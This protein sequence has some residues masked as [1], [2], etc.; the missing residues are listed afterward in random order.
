MGATWRQW[1]LCL[2][3]VAVVIGVGIQDPVFGIGLLAL[4]CLG[5]WVNHWERS[6]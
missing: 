2:F 1:F 4:I 3:G 5:L 6:D